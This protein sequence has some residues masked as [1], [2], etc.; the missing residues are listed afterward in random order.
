MIRKLF[1]LV[2][3]SY[4][5][6]IAEGS[7]RKHTVSLLHKMLVSFISGNYD[8]ADFTMTIRAMIY[9]STIRDR[10]LRLLT[11]LLNIL[12]LFSA[13]LPPDSTGSM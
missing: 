5:N 12:V 7:E 2:T 10:L 9:C 3:N 6:S 4:A 1:N 11:L 13:Q 8:A